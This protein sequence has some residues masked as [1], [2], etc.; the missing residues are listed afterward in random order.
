[1]ADYWHLMVGALF[2][3][4]EAYEY[5]RDRKDSFAHGLLLIVLIG[6]LVALAGIVGA[7]LRYASSPSADAIKNTV[8]THL[9]AM[10]FYSQMIQPFPQVEQQFLSGYNQFWENFG[11]VLL[12]FPTNTQGWSLLIAGII[13]TPVLWIILW[14]IYGALA[15]LI[16]SR[17]AAHIE[18][19]HVLG[20]LALATTPQIFSVVALFPDGGASMIALW[21]WSLI[22]NGMA[23]QTA[24]RISTRRA[25]W[26]ALFP[27]LVLLVILIVVGVFGFM[28][29]VSALRGGTP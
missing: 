28:G 4:R 24:Y 7:A 18:F 11:G 23:L 6:V 5:Q 27:L 12:G 9:Q 3:R 13:T 17:G 22:L 16:A 15:H 14:I 21:L 1:M 2:L 25:I 10:P 29:L 26:A 20:T 19:T 8:L